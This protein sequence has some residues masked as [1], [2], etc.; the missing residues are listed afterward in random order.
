MDDRPDSPDKAGFLRRLGLLVYAP[1]RLGDHLR[2][3]P[4]WWDALVLGA[5]LLAAANLAIPADVWADFLRTQQLSGGGGVGA[6]EMAEPVRGDLIRISASIGG[7]VAWVLFMFISAGIMAFIFAFVLGDEGRFRQYLAGTA[8]A[9][10]LTG[11]GALLVS[12]LK[13]ARRD[14]E[15]TLSV[16]TFLQGALRDTY[17]GS[18][19]GALDLFGLWA[20]VVMG[21]VFSRFDERRSAGSAVG[22]VLGLSLLLVGV[23]SWF[24]YRSAG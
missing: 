18:V 13:A 9:A 5:L 24:Q 8:H 4:V 15:L 14:P 12:P 11:M 21:I 19:L 2:S 22:I 16:G 20:W 1:G 7:S 23:V 17:L 10:L 6:G 3:R